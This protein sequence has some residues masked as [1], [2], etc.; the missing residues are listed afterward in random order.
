LRIDPN[1]PSVTLDVRDPVQLTIMRMAIN[2]CRREVSDAEKRE[3]IKTLKELIPEWTARDIAEATGF[4]ERWVRKYMPEEFK[5]PT[6]VEIGRES[7]ARR[8][9]LTYVTKP[10][11]Y[12]QDLLKL[13][14]WYPLEIL[15]VVAEHVKAGTAET[16]R[17]WIKA[18]LKA[19]YDIISADPELVA[20]ALEKTKDEVKA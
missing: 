19:M 7:A 1:W 3:F 20:A 2:L 9:G 14:K 5:E 15:D 6:K 4:S 10:P 11:T 16:Y 18:F 12:V 13:E 17:K 8:A